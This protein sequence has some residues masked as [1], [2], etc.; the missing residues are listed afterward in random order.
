M[1]TELQINFVD[2]LRKEGQRLSTY[3][4]NSSRAGR[5]LDWL[6]EEQINYLEV[7]YSDILSY[8]KHLK[9]KGTGTRQSTVY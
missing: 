3:N 9:K 4:G 1:K 5:F 6:A 8:I 7:S 2:Y